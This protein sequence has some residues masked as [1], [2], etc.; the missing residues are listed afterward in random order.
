MEIKRLASLSGPAACPRFAAAAA[1]RR[2]RRIVFHLA[3]PI[4]TTG[5]PENVSTDS[6]TATELRVNGDSLQRLYQQYL[7]D[8]YMVNRRY[9]RK[10]VWTVE[11]KSLL[12]DSV[13]KDLPIPL[14][15]LAEY[16]GIDDVK[17]EI[18]DGLQRLNAI[19]AFLENEFPVNEMYFDL[20]T[21]GDTKALRDAGNLT[22]KQPVLPRDICLNIVNYQLPV[23]TYRSASHEAIDEVFRRINS[24]GRK[25][26]LQEIRQAG[27]TSRSARLVRR[28]SAGVRGDATLTEVLP[29]KEMPKI[30]I[31]N[32]DLDYGIDEQRIFWIEQG[33]LDRDSV[34]ESRDEELILDLLLDMCLSAIATT[35]SEYRN[36][37]FGRGDRGG[38][39]SQEVLEARIQ[40][41]G[42]DRVYARFFNTLAVIK[43][44]ITASGQTWATWTITQ[45]NQRQIARYFQAVFV[46][47]YDLLVTDRMVVSDMSGLSNE[48]QGFWDRDLKVPGGGGVWGA[49]R[50]R[51]LFAAVKAHLHPFFTASSDPGDERVREI[52]SQFESTLQMS[53]T[54]A[55]LFELKQ[56]FLTLASPAVFD[57]NS[58]EKVLRTASA[59]ANLGPHVRGFI[60]VG[61]AD[62]LLDAQ[63][64]R[65]IHGIEGIS[66]SRFHITGTDHELQILNRSVD[67]QLRWLVQRIRNSKL[68]KVFGDSLASSLTPFE[69][70]G[71]LIWSLNPHGQRDPVDW[72]DR[73]YERIGNSTVEVTGQ[74]IVAL[75]RRF[76]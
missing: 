26:S 73:F 65:E 53:I 32:R 60:F 52:A 56:G 71:R 74:G 62:D 55:A 72:D 9:Q 49:D 18:I 23:S 50:K 59:M 8:A 68:N 34:R 48:L 4:R 14:I 2:R 63:R 36:A 39:T 22:Q 6:T 41:T 33:I 15:L 44:V 24:S 61:V 16:V 42:E 45:K 29:L 54:E 76:S 3:L 40:A 69:Y 17:F 25:L 64:V 30:S 37:A 35:G 28:I 20:E 66:F 1:G 10:L 21:L 38:A 67:E 31:T 5:D 46:P 11:E 27:V 70:A 12:I 43:D 7:D 75:S 58:F 47:I 57:D 19:F 13:Q 51:K